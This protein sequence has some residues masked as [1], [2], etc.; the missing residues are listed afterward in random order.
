MNRRERALT[1][2]VPADPRL[3][4][5]MR[6]A[7]AAIVD[8]AEYMELHENWAPNILCALARLDG[9]T[10]GI[11]ANQPQVLAGVLDIAACEKASRFVQYCDAFNIGLVTLLDVPGF[12]PG[13]AQEHA[14][15]WHHPPRRTPALCLR[16]CDRA[17]DPGH[18]PQG[19]RRRPS[20]SA[21]CVCSATATSS[22]IPTTRSNAGS[23]TTSSIP[24]TTRLVLIRALRALANKRACAPQRKHGNPLT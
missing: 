12:L 9:A 16:G 13:T 3:P 2:L 18:H 19:V 8:D 21:T 22:C 14:G 4:F 17:P 20:A 11:V 23:S 10:V 24:P 5:D 6:R 1:E 7:I 15:H